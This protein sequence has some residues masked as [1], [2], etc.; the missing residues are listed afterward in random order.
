MNT[1]AED[2]TAYLAARKEEAKLIDPENCELFEDYRSLT[3]PYG[4]F[5]R[6]TDW[7][8]WELF[9][10]NLQPDGKWVWIGDVP[11]ATYKALMKTMS[12]PPSERR[13]THQLIERGYRELANENRGSPEAMAKLDRVRD[14][15]HQVA[16]KYYDPAID[17]R[18]G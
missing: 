17:G 1:E 13:L 2:V 11:E 18:A 4:V 12:E 6:P 5:G 16:R 8:G 15:L 14:R 9:V 3:E 10:R 7:M